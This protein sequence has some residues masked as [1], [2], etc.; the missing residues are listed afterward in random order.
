MTDPEVVQAG[1]EWL[2]FYWQADKI[3][4]ARSRMV[5]FQDRRDVRSAVRRDSGGRAAAGRQSQDFWA[6]RGNRQRAVAAATQ[7]LRKLKEKTGR[8]YPRRIR[9]MADPSLCIALN[10]TYT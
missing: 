1:D 8:G 9:I 5:G 6:G 10:G 2:M 7:L 3:P 4:M